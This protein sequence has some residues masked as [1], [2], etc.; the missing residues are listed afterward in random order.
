MK[1]TANVIE[2]KLKIK[3]EAEFNAELPKFEGKEVIVDVSLPKSQRSLRQ[4]AYYQ[5]VVV[6][7]LSEYTGYPPKE[8]HNE[9]KNKFLKKTSMF[10][11]KDKDGAYHLEESISVGSTTR[12]NTKTFEEYLTQIRMWANVELGVFIP[13]PNETEY[14][15]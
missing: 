14:T 8:M 13:E 7:L 12:L 10:Q 15:Y 3:H 9:L 2:G 4:N 1:Y 11:Y 6:K 5:G